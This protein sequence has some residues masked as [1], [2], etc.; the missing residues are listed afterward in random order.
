[1]ALLV[2]ATSR[3]RRHPAYKLCQHHKGGVV[4]GA[5]RRAGS[6]GSGRLYP[7]P[8]LRGSSVQRWVDYRKFVGKSLP[9]WAKWPE[10]WLIP[11]RVS[12]V[13]LPLLD[14]VSEPAQENFDSLP[15]VACQ[16]GQTAGGEP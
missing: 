10:L 9:K 4:V 7:A 14:V 12:V 5:P 11:P 16:F 8:W 3:V 1:M 6:A 15:S 13:A 2:A